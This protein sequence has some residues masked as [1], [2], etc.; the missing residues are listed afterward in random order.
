MA[1]QTEPSIS[2]E[3]A[4]A[5]PAWTGWFRAGSRDPW[6]PVVQ[7]SSDTAAWDR[8]RDHPERGD[9]CVLPH[10]RHPDEGKRR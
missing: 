5:S 2:S 10:G 9:K 3:Q 1:T 8:L 6:R 7:A 4:A